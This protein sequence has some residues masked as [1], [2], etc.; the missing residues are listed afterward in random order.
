M[1]S[2]T[3][4]SARIGE[5][6]PGIADAAQV[7]R[8]HE[9][10]ARAH[11]QRGAEEVEAVRP[12]V[13]RQPAQQRGR[14]RQRRKPHRD[15]DPEDHRPMQMVG[16]QAAERRAAAAGR[17]VG[18]SEIA[19]IAAA[20]LGRDQIAEHDH[21]H[22]RQPAAAEA[23][24]DAAQ[25]Q[26][27]HV[28]RQRAN[29]RAGHVGQDRDAQREPAAVDVRDLAVE[30]D[31]RGR[32]Q[33]IGGDQPGQVVHVTEIAADGRQRARQNGL[34]ER[35]HEHRQQHAQHDQH[36]L[37]MRE[38][39]GLTAIGVGIHRQGRSGPS[40][41]C[42]I[43]GMRAVTFDAGCKARLRPRPARARHWHDVRAACRQAGNRCAAL[44]QNARPP[45]ARHFVAVAAPAVKLPG[46]STS[47]H[48]CHARSAYILGTS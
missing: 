17:G 27:Q 32:R 37:A 24:Q 39:R 6:R 14:D 42:V 29:Q 43:G 2:A 47:W 35:P 7:Q 25:D 30:R 20:L 3:A 41:L 8:Q 28:R 44:R 34:V 38:G 19:V 10:Y 48:C 11:D 4:N 26:H 46:F 16:D 33:Q 13:A 36:G 12:L 5:R 15:V 9:R 21:A 23:V 31:D 22:G 40:Y 1:I 45:V 18:R